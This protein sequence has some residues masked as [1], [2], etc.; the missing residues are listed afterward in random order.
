MSAQGKT[1]AVRLHLL[2]TFSVYREITSSY[3]VLT[4]SFWQP[5]RGTLISIYASLPFPAKGFTGEAMAVLFSGE[6]PRVRHSS[7]LETKDGNIVPWKWVFLIP[8]FGAGT[9]SSRDQ[10][11][12]LVGLDD[13]SDLYGWPHPPDHSQREIL[14]AIIL[15]VYIFRSSLT[16]GM[17]LRRSREG[18][19]R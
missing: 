17:C 7:W 5:G 10:R 19:L 16:D 9:G 13:D 4:M 14:A 3:F 18:A 1:R 15:V 2:L 6:S 8:I 12:R 11:R